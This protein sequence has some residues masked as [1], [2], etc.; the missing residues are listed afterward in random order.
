MKYQKI[1]NVLDKTFDNVPK[2]IAKKWIKFYN[3]SGRTEDRY[4]SSKRIRF[5][6]IQDELFLGW[7][8]MGEVGKKAP[9]PKI[10]HKYPT[11]MKLGTVIPY[12]RKTQEI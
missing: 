12:L 3:Q 4:K 2:F 11:M 8:Q 7:S 6:R 9:F 1:T 5:N 10:C